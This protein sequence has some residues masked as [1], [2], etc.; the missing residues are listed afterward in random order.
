MAT[1][2][3]RIEKMIDLAKQHAADFATRATEHDREGSFPLENFQAMRDSGYFYLTLPEEL[4]GMGADIHELCL[5]QFHLA[6]GCGSTAMATTMHLNAVGRRADIWR[7]TRDENTET[8]L[9]RVKDEG[10][11]VCG[12]NSDLKSGGD[13]RY[14]AAAGER[15]EGGYRLTAMYAFATNSTA[16]DNIDVMFNVESTDAGLEMLSTSLLRNTEGLTVHNDWDGMGMRATGSNMVSLKDVFIADERITRS[17]TPGT[18]TQGSLNAHAWFSTSVTATCLGVAQAAFDTAINDTVG[19]TRF[20]H[21]RTAEHFPGA[22]FDIALAHI[23]LSAALALLRQTT[24]DFSRRLTHTEDDYVAGEVCKYYCTRAAKKVVNDV[25][26]MIGGA[27]YLRSKP[28]ERFMRDVFC[29]TFFP[30][31]KHT[32]LELIGKRIFDVDWQTEPRFT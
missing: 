30:Q 16:A 5:S 26:E 11:V 27:S 23:E 6:Q 17:R 1:G 22:Q 24:S 12:I 31:N 19:R 8:A 9:R 29:G 13:P 21:Q 4:G 3:K 10:T 25:M 7:L 20:P 32:A 15:V 14:T 2:K 18:L 28:Y